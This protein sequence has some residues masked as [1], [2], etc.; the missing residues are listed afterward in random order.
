MYLVL[1]VVKKSEICCVSYDEF[2]EW[3][4]K[5]YVAM[6]VSSKHTGEEEASSTILVNVPTGKSFRVNMNRPGRRKVYLS[7]KPQIVAR[8]RFPDV[9]FE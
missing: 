8:N 7:P 4:S 3:L 1:I 9:L 5:R 6:L 2:K